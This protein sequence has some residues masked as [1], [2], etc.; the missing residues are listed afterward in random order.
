MTVAPA[1]RAASSAVAG[2]R[3]HAGGLHGPLHGAV[4]D[5]ALGG[6]V[7]LELDQ[8]E[9]RRL[10]VHRVLLCWM[11]RTAGTDRTAGKDRT[12][13]CDGTDVRVSGG[14]A[15]RR[16]GPARRAARRRAGRSWPVARVMPSSHVRL[17]PTAPG[18]RARRDL[19]GLAPRSRTPSAPGAAGPRSPAKAQQP[20]SIGTMHLVGDRLRPGLE[21]A[22]RCP[23]WVDEQ[24]GCSGDP[25]RAVRYAPAGAGS[26]CSATNVHASTTC[27]SGAAGRRRQP[28]WTE[29]LGAR[30]GVADHR[31]RARRR[32][33][34]RR[35]RRASARASRRSPSVR[36]LDARRAAA[37]GVDALR[38]Q[39]TCTPARAH[40]AWNAA[41]TPGLPPRP[42]PNIAFTQAGKNTASRRAG[43]ARRRGRAARR[44]GSSGDHERHD[45]GRRAPARA[46]AVTRGRDSAAGHGVGHG[47]CRP[48]AASSVAPQCLR[49]G[50]SSRRARPGL[51]LAAQPLHQHP[52]VDAAPGRPSRTCR[53]PRRCARPRSRR[54]RSSRSASRGVAREPA[55]RDRRG[56]RRSAAAGWG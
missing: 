45:V 54:R 13:G 15:V 18:R 20:Q 19:G 31:Q 44:A 50:A 56:E 8:D 2:V 3:Q 34:S 25:T 39:Q 6:E 17:Q 30:G 10:R 43:S 49:G 9:C 36:P 26:T 38:D 29:A 7:V 51:V 23:S 12:A 5:A 21:G 37:Q 42:G 28:A 55:V 14:R 48:D 35:A 16:P 40:S 24:V 53:R 22:G 33:A 11:Y 41:C 27:T 47:Q 46:A 1:A 4:Q 32:M 52:G